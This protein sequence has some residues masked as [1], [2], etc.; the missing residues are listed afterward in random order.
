MVRRGSTVR[1]RQRALQKPRKA[2]FFV[3]PELARCPVCG[4]YGAL[5]GAF[6][7]RRA[8]AG[9]RLE[10]SPTSRWLTGA[11]TRTSSITTAAR[12]RP[13]RIR[14][15]R[16]RTTR[17]R[18]SRT[19]WSTRRRQPTASFLRLTCGIAV[20]GEA[21]EYGLQRVGEALAAKD[22][23]LVGVSASGAIP[24]SGGDG[25]ECGSRVDAVLYAPGRTA[26]G[27]E[28]EGRRRG[29]RRGAAG[30]T[31]RARK[32]PRVNWRG[33]RWLDVYRWAHANANF[34]PHR[35]MVSYSTSSLIIWM[36]ACE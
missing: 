5:Y 16:L 12:Q 35:Q 10:L 4:G 28:S 3:S 1:V 11:D 31:R 18:H 8:S 21:F 14:N 9:R 30:T 15:A 29:A 7:S 34:P 33:V 22:R 25:P 2:G 13:A 26:R 19:F 36:L 6:G 17:R 20:N 23:F 32:I 24:E 27:R